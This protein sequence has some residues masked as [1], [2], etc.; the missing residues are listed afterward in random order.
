MIGVNMSNVESAGSYPRPKAGGY[1][2]R[3][4]N[5]TNNK[6][7]E[8][9]DIEFD[10]FE[11]EFKGYYRDMQDRFKFWGGKFSKSYTAKALPFLKGFIENI[12]ASN[13][14]TDGLVIGDFEDID[15]TKLPGLIVGM[16]VGEKAYI[17]NDGKEKVKLDTYNASFVPVEDIH[18]GN[19]TVPEFQPLEDKPPESA[20][21][22]DMSMNFGPVSDDDVPF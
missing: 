1:V 7:K 2:I 21:V 4:E 12:Q 19:F 18:S 13:E 8:R 22:V 6:Q 10:F 9:L 14:N 3:I 5:V 15:E 20:G 11:G 16:V 17:G